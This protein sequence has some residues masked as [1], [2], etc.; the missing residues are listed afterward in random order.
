MPTLDEV[1]VKWN[2]WDRSAV[3]YWV[4]K[5]TAEGRHLA[6]PLLPS[7]PAQVSTPAT[8]PD[9]GDNLKDAY[10]QAGILAAKKGYSLRK[11]AN[12]VNK[13]YGTCLSKNIVAKSKKTEESTCAEALL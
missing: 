13:K 10:K 4:R 12:K 11:A 3:H 7:P 5:Y 9:S 2:L 8:A 6:V 1:C